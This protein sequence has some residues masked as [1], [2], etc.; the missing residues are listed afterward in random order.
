[1]ESLASLNVT[2]ENVSKLN[3]FDCAVCKDCFELNE[4][5]HLLPCKHYFHCD[6]IKPWLDMVSSIIIYTWVISF[7]LVDDLTIHFFFLYNFTFL[8]I[9]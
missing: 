9:A 4:T 5:Y 2:E 1:M 7:Y 6:C 8:R 3:E